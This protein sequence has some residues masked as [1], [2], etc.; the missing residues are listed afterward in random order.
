LV[1]LQPLLGALAVI[2]ID[3]GPVPADKGAMLVMNWRSRYVE[4]TIFSIGAAEAKLGLSRFSRNLKAPP[5]ALERFQFV[6]M[7]YRLP[8]SVKLIRRKT[9]VILQPA[10]YE[11]GDP[12][13]ASGPGECR[14]AI[15]ESAEFINVHSET[16]RFQPCRIILFG[17]EELHSIRCPR[18]AH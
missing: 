12:I 6:R 7:K 3:I 8:T 15:D 9:G 16:R 5:P 11:F 4:P 13:G 17:G 18:R 2:D 14:N 10:V 1:L